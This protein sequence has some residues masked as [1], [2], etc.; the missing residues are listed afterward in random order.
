[1]PAPGRGRSAVVG[2]GLGAGG[3]SGEADAAGEAQAG[4]AAAAHAAVPA[5]EERLQARLAEGLGGGAAALEAALE[6]AAQLA[7][8][9]Q[10]RDRLAVAGALGALEVDEE[11][12][13]A[14]AQQRVVVAAE[15]PAQE[16]AAQLPRPG[17]ELRPGDGRV[18]QS[19]FARRPGSPS[20]LRAFSSSW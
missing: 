15:L 19:C 11:R 7:G 20:M 2:L 9:E 18:A 3:G 5:G 4:D 12:P 1:M 14:E 6:P 17:L 16:D 10:R 13:L 8:D